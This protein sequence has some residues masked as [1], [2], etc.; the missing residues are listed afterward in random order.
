[1][2][3][4][5]KTGAKQY[6]NKACYHESLREK[7]KPGSRHIHPE[8]YTNLVCAIVRRARQDIMLS[9]PG[10]HFRE[11]AEQFFLSGGFESLTGLDGKVMLDKIRAEYDRKLR[12]GAIRYD[13]E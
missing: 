9:S 12:K 7:R 8:G 5:Y 10:T 4:K 3:A 13:A 6:C 11:D 2:F 1:M